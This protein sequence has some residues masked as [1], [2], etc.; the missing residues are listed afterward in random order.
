MKPPRKTLHV[1]P[2]YPS[3]AAAQGVSGVVV[4]KAIIDTDGTI[5]DVQTLRSPN[6]SLNLSA[7]SAIRG[8]EFTPTLLN[9]VAVPVRMTATFNFV[10]D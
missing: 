4:L 10:Q 1:N 9:G 3:D 2:V 5:R 6:D 8:W 7:T